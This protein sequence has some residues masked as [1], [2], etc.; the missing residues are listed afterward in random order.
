MLVI[1]FQV[2]CELLLKNPFYSVPETWLS[3]AR[4]FI[5]IISSSS[6]SSSM[7]LCFVANDLSGFNSHEPFAFRDICFMFEAFVTPSWN[8]TF[9]WKAMPP[10]FLYFGRPTPNLTALSKARLRQQISRQS[11]ST[12]IHGAPAGERRLG[13]H[14]HSN[15]HKQNKTPQSWADRS[16]NYIMI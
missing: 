4:P 5:I 10:G 8:K 14:L 7:H 1:F 6:S 15:T 13:Q 11:S 3:G 16:I 12:G 2:I 9:I